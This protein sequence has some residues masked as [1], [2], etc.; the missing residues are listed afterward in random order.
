MDPTFVRH[1]QIE[2]ASAE[3][4]TIRGPRFG[5]IMAVKERFVVKY[6]VQ[7]TEKEGHALLIVEEAQLP[8]SAP[9]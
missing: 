1:M 7:V 9:K 8:S 6:G 5:R 2:A 4:S 3:L